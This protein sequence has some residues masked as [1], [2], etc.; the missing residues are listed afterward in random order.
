MQNAFQIQI[1]SIFRSLSLMRQKSISVHQQEAEK[2]PSALFQVNI[3]QYSILNTML[4][5]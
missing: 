4:K 2:L 5:I 3:L 1:A